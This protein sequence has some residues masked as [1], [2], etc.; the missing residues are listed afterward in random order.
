MKK[1]L[2]L[3]SG[4]LGGKANQLC[5][6]WPNVFAPFGHNKIDPFGSNKNTPLR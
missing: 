1:I 3:G 5:P 2:L 6:F 4:E